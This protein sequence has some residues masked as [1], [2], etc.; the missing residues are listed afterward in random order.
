MCKKSISL[1]WVCVSTVLYMQICAHRESLCL[2]TNRSVLSVLPLVPH[3]CSALPKP[4]SPPV[5]YMPN[6]IGYHGVWSACQLH[7]ALRVLGLCWRSQRLGVVIVHEQQ[8]PVLLR[9]GFSSKHGCGVGVSEF[10][11]GQIRYG[12]SLSDSCSF[13]LNALSFFT[14]LEGF[15]QVVLLLPC[16]SSLF[17]VTLPFRI[18]PWSWSLLHLLPFNCWSLFHY[19]FQWGLTMFYIVFRNRDQAASRLILLLK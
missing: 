19:S 5:W 7:S 11:W 3:A 12:I 15:V 17:L 9:A 8:S 18:I 14:D 2:R 13:L 16:S 6:K 1:V 10:I 4:P